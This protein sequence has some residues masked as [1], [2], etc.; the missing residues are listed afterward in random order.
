MK[1]QTLKIVN[2]TSRKLFY[3]KYLYSIKLYNRFS[4]WYLLRNFNVDIFQKR[5]IRKF[6]LNNTLYTELYHKFYGRCS[7]ETANFKKLNNI[8]NL[9]EKHK[10]SIR[11]SVSSYGVIIYTNDMDIINDFKS[12]IDWCNIEIS[13]PDDSALDDIKK[14]KFM[15]VSA[16]KGFKYQATI[17]YMN[18]ASFPD[19]IEKNQSL[20]SITD[21]T[22]MRLRDNRTVT[23]FCVYIKSE[24]AL[25]LL[26]LKVDKSN[27]QDI[28]ELTFADS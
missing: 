17:N 2:K 21:Y 9:L 7:I 12:K 11:V 22:K 23:R 18:D 20:F 4:G 26:G 3:K 5:N 28:Y 6:E 19:W 14:G 25:T 13:T 10:N 8:A 27:I 15:A 1:E 16:Y 24:K